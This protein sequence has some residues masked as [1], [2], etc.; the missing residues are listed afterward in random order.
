MDHAIQR[1]THRSAHRLALIEWVERE[2]HPARRVDVHAWPVTL[3]RAMDNDIVLDDPHVAA[4]PAALEPLDPAA[5]STIALRVLATRNGVALN[6][7]RV[8]GTAPRPLPASGA[9]LQMGTTLVRLRLPGEVLA[10]ERLLA[11]HAGATLPRTLLLGAGLMAL[12]CA[13]HAIA[14]DPGADFAAWVPTLFGLPLLVL[15]WCGLWALLSKLFQHRFD[16]VGH[17]RI[18]LPWLLAFGLLE[19]LWP[20]VAAAMNWPTGW[21]LTPALAALG[22]ALLVHA[23]LRHTL[24]ARPRAVSMAVAGMLLLGAGISVA[25]SLRANDSPF[26]TPYMSTLPLPGLRLADTVPTATL[27]QDMA[28]LAARLARR[29]QRAREEDRDDSNAPAEE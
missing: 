11:G 4:H 25:S 12:L 16:F 27:V 17:L 22:G 24:P 1:S 15:A 5:D 8:D 29:A 3:G 6:G 2:G 26:S 19:A 10:P 23:H 7:L 14:L 21:Q 9:L 28:P 13:Q 20:Q 18:A